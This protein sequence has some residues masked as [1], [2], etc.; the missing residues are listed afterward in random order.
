MKHYVLQYLAPERL[1][2]MFK[3]FVYTCLCING[4]E[5]ITDDINAAKQLL[6][7][8][9]SLADIVNT[10]AV[11]M[12]TIAWISLLV[13]FELE[14]WFLDDEVLRKRRVKWSLHI[15]TALCYMVIIYAFVGYAGKL[16]MLLDSVPYSLGNPCELV[17]TSTVIIT[18]LDEYHDITQA[19]CQA[20][21]PAA[22]GQIVGQPIVFENASYGDI[23]I[24]AWVDVINSATWLLIVVLLQVDIILQLKG[25]LTGHI[26]RGPAVFKA[27]LY[28]TLF[29]MAIVWGIYG[30][31]TDFWDAVLWLLGFLIIELNIFNWNQ[32]VE[33]EKAQQQAQGS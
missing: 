17:N 11:T 27:I 13:V 1:M 25:M 18:T 3:L 33:E 9:S 20:L 5:F 15:A 7:P 23:K 29:I 26:M 31:F 19:S 10:F 6:T 12:D 22:M 14:T 32:E 2:I 4:Y 21:N 16:I 8:E 24:L 30:S 28:S